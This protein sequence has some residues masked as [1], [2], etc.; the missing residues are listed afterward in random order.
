MRRTAHPSQNAPQVAMC[1]P[2]TLTLSPASKSNRM[3]KPIAGE[4]G[5][6]QQSVVIGLSNE[7]AATGRGLIP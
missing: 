2:L 4:R 6:N 5:L 1:C 7:V 3:R